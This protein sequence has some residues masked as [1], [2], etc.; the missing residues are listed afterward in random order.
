MITACKVEAPK[1]GDLSGDGLSVKEGRIVLDEAVPRLVKT[2]C[3]VG[4]AITWGGSE[5]TC[6]EPTA[7]S[8]AVKWSDV[9]DVPAELADG[10]DAD[11]LAGISCADGS[12]LAASAGGWACQPFEVSLE[13][14]TWHDRVERRGAETRTLAEIVEDLRERVRR[15][16]SPPGYVKIPSGRFTMGSAANAPGRSG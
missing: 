2:N 7:T 4:D 14:D 10:R 1:A 6:G 8:S 3:Q 12:I 15:L 13:V 5:M 16:E 11:T 9:R